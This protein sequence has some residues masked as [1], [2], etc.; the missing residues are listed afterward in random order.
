MFGWKLENRG[1]VGTPYFGCL[2][3]GKNKILL[4]PFSLLPDGINEIFEKSSIMSP[5]QKL[6]L[7]NIRQF[8]S[9]LAMA[10]LQLNCNSSSVQGPCDLQIYG[11]LHRRSGP[12]LTNKEK[13][14]TCLQTFFNPEMQAK[15]RT[16]IYV[17]EK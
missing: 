5:K 9:G 2:C 8:N 3:C 10:S 7:K 13:V 12:M 16:D 15:F 14:P 11:Q 1:S 6:F 4:P 17:S